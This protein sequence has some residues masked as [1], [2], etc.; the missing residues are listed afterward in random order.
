MQEYIENQSVAVSVKTAKLTGRALAKGI[1]FALRQIAKKRNK[2]KP[3]EQNMKRLTRDGRD[4]DSIEVMGRIK[5]FER[6]ARKYG[7]AY[8]AEKDVST[9]PPKFTVYFKSAQ[10]GC[11]TAA[12]KEYTALM[13]GKGVKKPSILKQLNQFKELL[14]NQVVDR[15]KNK[16]HGG[17]ER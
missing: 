7:I 2:L 17:H 8:H 13:L 9:V 14:K 15:V 3:G 16:E 4:T 10:K 5:S 11:L 12:F 6:I 1:N